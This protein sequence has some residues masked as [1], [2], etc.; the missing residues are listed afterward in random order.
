[1]SGNSLTVRM[2]FGAAAG[3]LEGARLRV[4]G[5]RRTPESMGIRVFVDDPGADASTPMEG[6]R[7]YAGTLFVYG[8]GQADPAL[9]SH[10]D[11][12]AA[13]RRPYD[14]EIDLTGALGAID[15]A[16]KELTVTLV[17]VD[18]HG[19]GLPAEGIEFERLALVP[20]G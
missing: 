13:Q 14:Q 8:Y 12:A 15:P 3:G 17:A 2:P 11:R 6:N 16:S 20:D 18:P 9:E 4:E 5:L 10:P 7:C 19:R 1:M